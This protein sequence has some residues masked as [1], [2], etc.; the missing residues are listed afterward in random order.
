MTIETMCFVNPEDVK[1]VRI[2]CGQCGSATVVPTKE[3]NRV[4]VLVESNC[5]TCGTPSGFKR[6]TMECK[7]LILF[8]ETLGLL[9]EIMKG[10]NMK[11]SLRIEC[12]P[13]E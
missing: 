12:P 2:T 11:Y 6:D 5:V 13:S 4:A 3:L 7:R 1:E 9:A 8:T 10:R